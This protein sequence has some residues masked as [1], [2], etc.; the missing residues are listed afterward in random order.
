MRILRLAVLAAAGALV[1]RAWVRS[2]D[3]AGQRRKMTDPITRRYFTGA[4]NVH[5]DEETERLLPIPRDRVPWFVGAIDGSEIYVM[6]DQEGNSFFFSVEHELL[7]QPMERVLWQ[8]PD[9]GNLYLMWN[10]LFELRAAAQRHGLGTRS[11]AVELHEVA[12]FGVAVVGCQA[13]GPAGGRNGYYTWPLLGFDAKL[14]ARDT[15]RL[16]A[17]LS[18]CSTLNELF[19]EEGGDEHWRQHGRAMDVYFD[20]EPNSASW[21]ILK[22]YMEVRGITL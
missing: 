7:E 3:G 8:D 19:M 4:S 5:M 6:L 16:P 12:R 22:T 21:V 15:E 13:A 1:V 14:A 2:G 10:Q 20:L 18:H 9:A 17:H 11:L